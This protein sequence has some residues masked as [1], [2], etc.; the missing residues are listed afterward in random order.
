MRS[1]GQYVW[2][3]HVSYANSM[4]AG[5]VLT[6][7]RT[8]TQTSPPPTLFRS[9]PAAGALRTSQLCN[10][11]ES[12]N[13]KAQKGP[14]NQ[15][16]RS[17]G[18]GPIENMTV[19]TLEYV[20]DKVHTPRED[21]AFMELATWLSSHAQPRP[22]LITADVSGDET[23]GQSHSAGEAHA[24]SP[25][26]T[27]M[28]YYTR[29]AEQLLTLHKS[30]LAALI[31]EPPKHDMTS[32]WA[33]QLWNSIPQPEGR[34]AAREHAE[35][36]SVALDMALDRLHSQHDTAA[37]GGRCGGEG[38]SAS[39]SAL[40]SNH[41]ED[42]EGAATD[43]AAAEPPWEE[44]KAIWQRMEVELKRQ[45]GVH[46]HE[47]AALL[48]RALQRRDERELDQQRTLQRLQH[49]A[50]AAIASAAEA[51]GRVAA[52]VAEAEHAGRQR[53]SAEVE[54]DTLRERVR[55]M[56]TKTDEMILKYRRGRWDV[57]EAQVRQREAQMQAQ[58]AEWMQRTRCE[59]HA[60]FERQYQQT[61]REGGGCD[62]AEGASSAQQPEL[63]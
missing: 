23:A 47:H 58:M 19:A 60:E 44:E 40:T 48:R 50:A 4:P 33:R 36:L 27:D 5:P 13:M 31:Q 14:P 46:C 56:Q 54:V 6:S 39:N 61:V 43:I 1:A 28:A 37:L 18:W 53:R 49:S 3:S 17:T 38:I 51:E 2:S 10:P 42:A 8:T 20:N 32:Y 26:Q 41:V 7:K 55:D 45:V 63:V 62:P 21:R 24:E 57:I 34:P 30:T 59:L 15:S 11:T 29:L 9:V 52:A 35:Q 22:G 25:G 16:D 12:S